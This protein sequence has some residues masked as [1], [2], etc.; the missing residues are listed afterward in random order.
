M[1]Y[2]GIIQNGVVVF[3]DSNTPPEGSKV[4]V[5]L[6]LPDKSQAMPPKTIYERLKRVA[7]TIDGLP[8]DASENLDHYLYGLPKQE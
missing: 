1:I 7:G 4:V 8:E 2:R 6:D 5:H 3:D